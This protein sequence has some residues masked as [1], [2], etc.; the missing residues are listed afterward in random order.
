MAKKNEQRNPSIFDIDGRRMVQPVNAPEGTKPIAVR[1][2]QARMLRDNFDRRGHS[3]HSVDGSLVW[4]IVTHCIEQGIR[5]SVTFGEALTMVER[6][7]F[8]TEV[9]QHEQAAD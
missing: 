6:Q 4:V 7:A 8:H 3:T 1:A 5:Y 2:Q 9:Q